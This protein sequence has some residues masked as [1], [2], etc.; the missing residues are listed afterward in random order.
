MKLR[1]YG[2]LAAVALSLASESASAREY[3]TIEISMVG[4]HA[5][6]HAGVTYSGTPTGGNPDLPWVACT[7]NWIYF[8]EYYPSGTT[9]DPRA[10]VAPDRLQTL[11]S[12]ATV[13]WVG[14]YRARVGIDR[15]PVS[16]KCY[17]SQIYLQ[18]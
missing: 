11:L 8:H 6:G 3:W 4:A 13:G 17:G 12:T 9:T 5:S 7:G 15:D 10:T 16:G 14:N 1:I 18:R 2:A